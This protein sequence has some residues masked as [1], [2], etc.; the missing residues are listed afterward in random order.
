[1]IDDGWRVMDI[2][3]WSGC[4][5]SWCCGWQDCTSPPTTA[6][7]PST[8]LF[9]ASSSCSPTLANENQALSQHTPSSIRTAS[10][11]TGQWTLWL[12]LAGSQ[13]LQ[14]QKSQLPQLPKR[15]ASSVR[16]SSRT[17]QNMGIS[18]VFVEVG[19]SSRNVV[20]WRRRD[21]LRRKG[22]SDWRCI[23]GY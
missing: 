7:R 23:D 18:L 10:D 16:C 1:M 20:C 13:A 9:L 19:G 3:L 21:E 8:S 5:L 15:W 12:Y 22:R 6:S 2:L 14:P 4:G 17:N 11:F